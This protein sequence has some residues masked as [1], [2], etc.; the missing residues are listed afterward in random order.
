MNKLIVDPKTESEIDEI[1]TFLQQ[2]GIRYQTEDEYK[3][4]QELAARK[5]LVAWVET[6]PKTDTTE[7]DTQS[8]VKKVREERYGRRSKDSN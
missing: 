4:E 2:K 7:H 5:E 3:F 6:L 1:K 8:L